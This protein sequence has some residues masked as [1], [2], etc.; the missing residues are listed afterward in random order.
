MPT[1]YGPSPGSLPQSSALAEAG[2]GEASISE[3]LSRDPAGLGEADLDRIIAV[4]REQREKW[5]LAEKQ[6]R[7]PPAAKVPTMTA[8]ELGL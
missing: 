6:G 1:Q 4:M 2:S 7:K 8:E 5:A 3:L